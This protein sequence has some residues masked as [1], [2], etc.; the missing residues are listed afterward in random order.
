MERRSRTDS[1]TCRK[2]WHN[3]SWSSVV[4]KPHFIFNVWLTEVRIKQ[5]E[6]GEKIYH[7]MM[8]GLLQLPILWIIMFSV[9]HTKNSSDSG[10]SSCC[11][12][13]KTLWELYSITVLVFPS[14]KEAGDLL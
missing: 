3:G 5:E 13:Q 10:Q 2:C 14:T 9:I 1:L 8:S 7:S 4:F 6:D 12:E 11:L